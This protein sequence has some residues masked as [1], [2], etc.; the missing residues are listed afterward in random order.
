VNVT[1]EIAGVGLRF[2]PRGPPDAAT[3]GTPTR[4][5]S[6]ALGLIVRTPA[7]FELI[8]VLVDR[9]HMMP[10]ALVASDARRY[11]ECASSGSSSLGRA[12]AFQAQSQ[13][14]PGE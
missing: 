5:G 11:N 14:M 2:E 1:L 12:A 10:D 9:T 4:T 13:V 7:E 8:I 6:S 3:V